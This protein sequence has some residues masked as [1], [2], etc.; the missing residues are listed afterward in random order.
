VS[1]TEHLN[2]LSWVELAIAA[3][4]ILVNGAI[5]V[6]LRLGL[7]KKLAIAAL[8]TVVQ[9]LA[10]GYVLQWV[11]ALNRWYVVLAILVVMTLLAGNATT[12][13]GSARYAGM[14]IDGL[15]S[16][17]VSSWLVTAVGLFTV[18][19]IHPWYEPRYAIP[20][21]GM[22]LGNTLSGVSVGME[23]IT[24]ELQDKRDQIEM[25]LA[26]GATRW[27][28]FR[29]A[30]V[31]A[32]RAGMMPAINAMSVVGIVSLPG[33]MTG[34]V[35]AGQDPQQAI[36]Y[37]IV[38]MFLITAASGLGTVAIVLLAFRRLFSAEHRFLYWRL[39]ERPGG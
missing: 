35:L 10:I 3:L 37:Q 20:I 23:R 39:S 13:R 24:N 33:M 4:L 8:R 25:L 5:S 27:E 34:Q 28:A 7:E 36:R 2:N 15:L 11:F 9:L 26:L 29:G 21:L 12:E 38:I 16:V 6:A 1:N 18:L 31:T 17:W 19:R 32:V 22:V 14:G 30:A